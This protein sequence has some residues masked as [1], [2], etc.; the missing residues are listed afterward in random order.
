MRKNAAAL[1]LVMALAVAAV[2]LALCASTH[3]KDITLTFNDD[4]QRA[5]RE[6]PRRGDQGLRIAGCRDNGVFRQEARH[7]AGG[8]GK[9][10]ACG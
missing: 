2:T 4:E 6:H 7:G 3:A 9:A 1:T 10:S 8:G 5:F